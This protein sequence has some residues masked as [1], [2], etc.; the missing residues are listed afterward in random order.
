M[1]LHLA[2]VLGQLG[3]LTD[4]GQ[5]YQRAQDQHAQM[6]QD[7]RDQQQR[8]TIQDIMNRAALQENAR[9]VVAGTVQDQMNAPGFQ[10]PAAPAPAA[11]PSTD[12]GVPDSLRPN[13]QIPTPPSAGQAPASAPIDV[14]G[15]MVPYYRKPDASRTVKYRDLQGNE[16][17]YELYT[18]EEQAERARRRQAADLTAKQ[19]AEADAAETTR[20]AYGITPTP[21]MNTRIGAAEGTKWLPA[22]WDKIAERIINTTKAPNLHFEQSVDDNGNVTINGYDDRTGELKSTSRVPGAGKSAGLSS[23]VTTDDDGNVTVFS[24]DKNGKVKSKVD[25]GGIGKS[26]QNGALTPGQQGV[27]DRFAQKRLD[28]QQKDLAAVQKQ[29]DDEHAFRISAGQQ[30]SNSNLADND[31][32]KLQAALKASTFKVQAYQA[33]KAAIMNTK[34]PSQQLQAQIP[35]GG[36]ATSPDGHVWQKKGG[37]VYIVR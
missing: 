11:P 9:P 24:T 23:H 19:M 10:L 30:L 13:G 31:R 4:L 34:P 1:G 14:P 20:Q 2:D 37:I 32:Q 28:Q 17:Q 36:Q 8:M 12:D 15:Q 3:G 29:E 16:S 5:R 22:E 6:Q 33:R 35:E 25:L 18:P 21:G 27:Q 26:R 7:L